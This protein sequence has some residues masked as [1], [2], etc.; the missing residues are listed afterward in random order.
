MSDNARVSVIIPVDAARG[1]GETALRAVLASDL[2]ELEVIL[3]ENGP[4]DR[5]DAL[6]AATQDSRV[7][8]VRLGSGRGVLRARNVAIAR[9]RAPYVAFLDPEDVLKPNTLSA[10]V[11]ALDGNPEAG[12]AFTDF[13]WVSKE[14]MVIRSRAISGSPSART[15]VGEPLD[16]HWRLIKQ[17]HLAR[18]LLHENLM[19]TSGLVVRR[20]LFTEIGPFNEQ[21]GCCADLDLWF[22]LAHRCD[23]LYSAEVGYSRRGGP[24]HNASGTRAASE[25]C[26]AVLRRERSRWNERAA[27][28]QLDRRIAQ[29]LA[30]IAY[31][32]RRR[33]HRLRSTA[34]F[35]YA[36]ATCPDV[37]WLGGMLGS[38]VC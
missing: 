25:D 13:E 2:L 26:I 31:D 28:R 36:F 21:A 32:E 9:A 34:T 23:A 4:T 10:A 11:R 7:L 16:G 12:F 6:V 37:R 24:G 5:C 19:E 35:A 18:A 15:L 22:R 8:A 20:Q 27:R 14:G 17:V 29:N 38:I 1:F 33:R 30:S 3:V